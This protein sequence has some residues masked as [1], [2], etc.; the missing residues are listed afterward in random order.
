MPR[1]Y[2]GICG[3]ELVLFELFEFIFKICLL[4]QSVQCEVKWDHFASNEE[5]LKRADVENIGLSTGHKTSAV[6][7]STM[8]ARQEWKS[9]SATVST[10][11]NTMRVKEYE[12]RRERRKEMGN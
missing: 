1:M 4:S 3:E 5:L 7:Q 6:W 9:L 11:F 8:N 2:L 12:R 10:K